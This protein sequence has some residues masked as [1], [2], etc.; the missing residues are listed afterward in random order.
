VLRYADCI[1][2]TIYV[3]QART[4]RWGAKYT[5]SVSR[6]YILPETLGLNIKFYCDPVVYW[7]FDYTTLGSTVTE[8][9]KITHMV[10]PE[11]IRIFD[12]LVI[13]GID[14]LLQS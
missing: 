11:T 2:T 12:A 14:D 5:A 8:F 9:W 1:S 7:P 10:A 13:L 4:V 6:G 3:G